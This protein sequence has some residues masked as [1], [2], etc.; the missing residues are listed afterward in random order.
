MFWVR[1]VGPR[2]SALEFLQSC[3]CFRISGCSGFQRFGLKAQ[4]IRV[5]KGFQDLYEFRLSEIQHAQVGGCG[6]VSSGFRSH[7]LRQETW[8]TLPSLGNRPPLAS[9]CLNFRGLAPNIGFRVEGLLFTVY[10]NTYQSWSFRRRERS[11]LDGYWGL[12]VIEHGVS[13]RVHGCQKG[14]QDKYLKNPRLG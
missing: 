4:F 11:L 12:W 9:P 10:E 5:H 14:R 2:L 3:G 6:S 13:A 8:T 1:G 7:A